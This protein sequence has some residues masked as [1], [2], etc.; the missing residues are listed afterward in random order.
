[1]EIYLVGGAIRDQLLN[2]P[3]TEKDWLVVGS[4]PEEMLSLGYT[5]VGKD[6][7]VFLHPST[8]EE[9]ALARTERKTAPGYKG[10]TFHTD[11]TVSIEED[12]ERR[13]LTINA[14]AQDSKGNLIDPYHGKDDLQK[15]LLQHVSSAFSEDPVR[16]LRVARFAAKLHHLGFTIAENTL[17][18]MQSMVEKGETQHLVTERVWQ[19][20]EK[21]L[22]E[23]CPALFFE[24]LHQ[25]HAFKDIFPAF[26][27]EVLDQHIMQLT[28][29]SEMTDKRSHRFAAFIFGLDEP[30]IVD[31]S[32]ALAIPNTYR[33]IALL[34][35]QH[36]ATITQN[37]TWTSETLTFLFQKTDALRKPERFEELLTLCGYLQE[38]K[39]TPTHENNSRP[40][41]EALTHYREV[42]HQQLI[43][44]GYEKAE[45]GK[46]ITRL[47]STALNN[48]LNTFK[49]K[50]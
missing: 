46:A 7:P 37:D 13:D 10:F 4:S 31:L 11:S 22:G 48:W 42:N 3:F 50:K 34:T 15:K 16:V 32:Q 27:E 14:I 26:P 25:C 6:F 24:T 38:I 20:C 40:L 23:K 35:Q 29:C 39:N 9:Y 5:P 33:D 12:L 17:S 8:H 21:A 18:L 43:E 49:N 45:L 36:Y 2:I 47:R 30:T 41:I 28:Q 19:E 1:M 44:Q